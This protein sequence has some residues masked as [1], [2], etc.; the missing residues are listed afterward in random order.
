MCQRKGLSSDP[1]SPRLQE[2]EAPKELFKVLDKNG[3]GKFEVDEA[4]AL[5]K[6]V[7]AIAAEVSSTPVS[8]IAYYHSTASR[9]I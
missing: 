2:E 7:A 1:C 5:I 6:L 4:A 9:V 8:H 3:N